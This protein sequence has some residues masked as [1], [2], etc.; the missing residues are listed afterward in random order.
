MR[1]RGVPL[2]VPV[3]RLLIIMYDVPFPLV[4]A[5]CSY[6]RDA[7]SVL[8]RTVQSVAELKAFLQRGRYDD[9]ASRQCCGERCLE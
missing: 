8:L 7:R 1:V 6:C 3:H 4:V 2:V 5:F 9:D